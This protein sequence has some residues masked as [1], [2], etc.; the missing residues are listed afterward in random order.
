MDLT[1]ILKLHIKLYMEL[2]LVFYEIIK[3]KEVLMTDMTVKKETRFLEE[4]II[5][6]SNI[7]TANISKT[8]GEQLN[9]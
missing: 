5:Q 4:S 2:C 7:I 9:S 3:E 1:S 6:I 8:K